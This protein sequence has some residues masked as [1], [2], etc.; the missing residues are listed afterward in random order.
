MP[1]ISITLETSHPANGW[2][3]LV[4]PRNISPMRRTF[5][6]F[7]V[8]AGAGPESGL[9]NEA[10]PRNMALMSVTKDTSHEEMS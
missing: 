7:H 4:A 1:P 6:T 3:K 2:L 9:L 8:R 10:A 5:D